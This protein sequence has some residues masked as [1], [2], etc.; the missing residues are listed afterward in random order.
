MGKEFYKA[1]AFDKNGEFLY[2]FANVPHRNY[3]RSYYVESYYDNG[4]PKLVSERGFKEPI[5]ASALIL[6]GVWT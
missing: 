5:N 3:E 4:K 2:V 1:Y 6:S